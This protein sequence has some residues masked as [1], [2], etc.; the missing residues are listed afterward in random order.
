MSFPIKPV[1]YKKI[2]VGLA[3]FLDKYTFLDPNRILNADSIRGTPLTQ[4]LSDNRTYSI[5]AGNSFLLFELLEDPDSDN[6]I[7]KGDRETSMMTVQSYKL[8]MMI[9]GNSS[10]TDSQRISTIFKQANLALELRDKGIYVKGVVPIIA[11]NEFIND[12]YI[13]RRDLTVDIQ[14]TYLFDD[15]SEDEGYFANNQEIDLIVKRT[16]EIN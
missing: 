6:F 2:I 14:V 4:Y 11:A 12:T 5:E 15:V 9:Y 1:T 7:T 10:V 13:L 16:S 3:K 8:N